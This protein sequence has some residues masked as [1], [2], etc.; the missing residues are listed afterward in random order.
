MGRTKELPERKAAARLIG[1]RFE[2]MPAYVTVWRM[3]GDGWEP[4]L[5]VPSF[6]QDGFILGNHAKRSREIS[7][8]SGS[9]NH[10]CSLSVNSPPAMSVTPR[11]PHFL[12]LEAYITKSSTDLQEMRVSWR[13][14]LDSN[15]RPK[16]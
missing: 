4:Y 9:R 2:N 12:Q 7:N 6:G 14:R 15:Q 3:A 5:E 8:R 13:L 1:K 10:Q 16:A 11:H